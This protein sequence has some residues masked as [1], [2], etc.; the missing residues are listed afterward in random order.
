MPLQIRS[1]RIVENGIERATVEL[2]ISDSA[3]EDKTVE[4]LHICTRVPLG[5][6]SYLPALQVKAMKRAT[7]ILEEIEKMSREK[8]DLRKS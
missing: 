6:D 7:Q 8:W 1:T 3:E 5:D 4:S 2:L